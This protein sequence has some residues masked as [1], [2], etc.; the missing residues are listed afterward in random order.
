MFAFALWD[1]RRQRL[2]AARD[3]FGIKPFYYALVD[4][5]LYFAS[6]VKALLPFLPD[7][8]T[9]PEALAEYLT[10]QYTIGEKTLFKHVHQLLPGH[11]LVA[12][13]GK[14]R[15]QAL[16]GRALRDRLG[17]QRPLFR[18]PAARAA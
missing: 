16:L 9:D 13:N 6:E 2:F 3:R 1:E 5:V 10:F 12:E 15:N 17:P 7:I 11:S 18:A 14:V 4:G 8:D